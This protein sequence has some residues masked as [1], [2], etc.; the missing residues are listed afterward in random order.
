MHIQALR[1]LNYRNYSD[2]YVDFHKNLNILIGKNGQGKTNIIEAIYA[3]AFGKSFRTN[4][5]KEL[6]KFNTD[7]AF[8]MGRIKREYYDDL[9]DIE[10]LISKNNSKGIKINKLSLDKIAN[11]IGKIN[12][13]IFSPEDLRLVKEGP[14]ERRTFID[15]ELSQIDPKYY[16]YIA[17]YNKILVQRNNL[18]KFKELDLNLLNVYNEQLINLGSYIFFKRDKFIKRIAKISKEIHKGLTDSKEDLDV[19]YS[20]NISK[21]SILD[22]NLIKEEYKKL[23]KES[24]NVDI[25]RQNTKIGPHKDDLK[26]LINTIDARVYGS[27][28]Q[29]RTSSISIKLSQIELINSIKNEYPIVLLDDIFSELDEKRQSLLINQLKDI[30]VFVTSA[31]RNHE[32]IFNKKSC[33]I[34]YIEDGKILNSYSI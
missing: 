29:Q 32:K 24:L 2:L 3:F 25:K 8:L 30:Q 18:L 4:K 19:L 33:K 10:L 31:E 7:K 16:N 13:V 27:Q 17:S 20:S 14:K 22:I 23:L 1:L 9:L 12:V 26:V 5:D 34:F 11:L 21:E 6:I 15:K 28:G